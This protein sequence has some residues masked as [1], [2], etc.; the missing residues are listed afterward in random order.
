MFYKHATRHSF[1]YKIVCFKFYLFQIVKGKITLL[2]DMDVNMY[3]STAAPLI[4]N[5]C[6]GWR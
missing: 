4:L 3:S 5:F 2:H 6:V 1:T